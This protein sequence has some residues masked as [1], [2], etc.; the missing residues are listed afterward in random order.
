MPTPKEGS[1]WKLGAR[2]KN[3]KLR[4]F[5]LANRQ[6]RYFKDEKKKHEQ[7][8]LDI[9][10]ASVYSLHEDTVVSSRCGFML[11]VKPLKASRIFLLQCTDKQDK[12]LWIQSL[13]DHGGR[14]RG[15]VTQLEASTVEADERDYVRQLNHPSKRNLKLDE[16]KDQGLVL[17][18]PDEWSDQCYECTSKFSVVRRRHHCRSC[19]RVF[20]SKCR[21]QKITVP[22]LKQKKQ[23]KV[24]NTCY[25]QL[26]SEQVDDQGH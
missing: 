15:T 9:L 17:W 8:K 11:G 3:W 18:T 6:L 13:E 7:G 5:H 24:C 10:E 12:L 19:G 1:L 2:V 4:Y 26:Y 22:R 20:C 14:N 16:S 23:V 21:T 25:D